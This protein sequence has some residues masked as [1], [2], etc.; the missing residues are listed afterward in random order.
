MTLRGTCL[1]FCSATVCS[2]L[3]D[4]KVAPF[5][6]LARIHGG[7]LVA[8]ESN[9]WT[10]VLCVFQHRAARSL[11]VRA[12]KQIVD[13]FCPGSVESLLVGMVDD[14]IVD[15]HELQQ[16]AHRLA[17]NSSKPGKIPRR[18]VHLK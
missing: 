3:S 4:A 5:P 14:E 13:H 11:A 9:R 10:A 2:A 12:V 7:Y 16:I 6:S 8:P 1:T 17:E 18:K 15:P